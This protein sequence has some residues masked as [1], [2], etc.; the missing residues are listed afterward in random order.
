M[1]TKSP[2]F[3]GTKVDKNPQIFIDDIFEVVDSMDVTPRER[4]EIDAY[5]LKDEAQ[6]WFEQWKDERPLKMVY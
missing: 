2:T 4:A 1:R 5:Q 3:H 6:V